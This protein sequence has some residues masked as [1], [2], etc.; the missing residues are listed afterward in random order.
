MQANAVICTRSFQDFPVSQAVTKAE[1]RET[2]VSL[3]GP[4]SHD[5]KGRTPDFNHRRIAFPRETYSLVPLIFL[6]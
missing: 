1:D 5:R 3:S 6:L 2:E 4:L